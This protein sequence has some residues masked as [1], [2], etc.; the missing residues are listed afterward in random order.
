MSEALSPQ[1]RLLES[2]LFFA[3]GFLI[4]A[5]SLFA[6]L[7]ASQMSVLFYLISPAW[8]VSLLLP[9]LLPRELMP[10]CIAVF[11]LTLAMLF[12]ASLDGPQP[13]ERGFEAIGMFLVGLCDFFF[14]VGLAMRGLRPPRDEPA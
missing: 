6:G 2:L 14:V 7:W 11:A 5:L 12:K 3:M 10:G 13:S 8:L 1:L 4:A 9:L